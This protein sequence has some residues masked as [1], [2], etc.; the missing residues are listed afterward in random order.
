MQER[1]RPIELHLGLFGAADGEVNRAQGMAGVLR[2]L[3]FCF[4]CADRE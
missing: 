4:V 3:V 2:N 1:N